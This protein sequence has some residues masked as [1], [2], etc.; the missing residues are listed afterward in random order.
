[1]FSEYF[2]FWLHVYDCNQNTWTFNKSKYDTVDWEWFKFALILNGIF[3]F[4]VNQI[5]FTAIDANF[6][7]VEFYLIAHIT[8]TL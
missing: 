6:I 4:N 1:M 7:F 2:S 8:C 5:I 3:N